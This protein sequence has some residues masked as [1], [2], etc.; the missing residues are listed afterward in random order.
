MLKKQ[1][2]VGLIATAVASIIVIVAV[3]VAV[4][5]GGEKVI[6]PSNGGEYAKVTAMVLAPDRRAGGS[7]V[8]IRSTSKDSYL[9]TN[10]HVCELV[11]TGGFVKTSN[12]EYKVFAYKLYPKHDLCLINIKTNLKVNTVLAQKNPKMYSKITASGHPHLRPVTISPGYLSNPEIL[13]IMVGMEACTGDEVDP[14]DMMTCLFMRQKPVMRKFK[15]QSTSCL[16]MPGSSG[17][18]VFNE[19]GELFA[20]MFAGSS[21]GLS[22]G[23]IVPFEFLNDF[24]YNHNKYKWQKPNSKIK[25]RRFLVDLF[26][27]RDRCAFNHYPVCEKFPSIWGVW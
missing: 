24:L 19:Q 9:L 6:L 18:G 27:I 23:S 14:Q 12:K 22:Y 5:L 16:I 13:A 7:G 1:T 21:Q 11:Q 25:P 3:G 8:V 17:S 4:K 10:K 20:L 15:S 26:K 2:K